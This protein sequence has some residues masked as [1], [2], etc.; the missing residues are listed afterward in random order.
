[1]N[2]HL[3]QTNF[4][5]LNA[6]KPL[7]AANRHA[8]AAREILSGKRPLPPPPDASGLP[9]LFDRAVEA[10]EVAEAALRELDAANLASDAARVQLEETLADLHSNKTEGEALEAIRAARDADDLCALCVRRSEAR[11]GQAAAARRDA[12]ASL[13]AACATAAEAAAIREVVTVLERIEREIGPGLRERRGREIDEAIDRIAISAIRPAEI[14]GA[15]QFL[16]ERARDIQGEQSTPSAIRYFLRDAERIIRFLS[17]P[18]SPEP[19]PAPEP[20]PE[21]KPR[22]GFP[23]VRAGR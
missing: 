22:R 21:E 4:T 16:H 6:D 14:G 23:K 3:A 15:A 10:V 17:S 1:M 18:E 20:Q 9:A 7:E 13:H 11:A 19:Q 12:L 2:T 8:L 5:G